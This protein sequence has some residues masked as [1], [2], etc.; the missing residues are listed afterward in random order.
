MRAAEWFSGKRAAGRPMSGGPRDTEA[1]LHALRDAMRTIVHE[2]PEAD[3]LARLVAAYC[4]RARAESLT[5]EHMLIRL[6]RALD[7]TPF[8]SGHNSMAR[9][10]AR[11]HVVTLAINAYYDDRR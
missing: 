4:E 1:A 3:G 10:E 9:E 2:G 7:E 6:K 5:P 8:P 11:A